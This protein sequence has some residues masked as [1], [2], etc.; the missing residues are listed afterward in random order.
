MTTEIDDD[1]DRDANF[2][3]KKRKEKKIVDDGEVDVFCQHG[4][5]ASCGL[6][7]S[8]QGYSNVGCINSDPNGK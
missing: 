3:Q 5:G 8:R 1:D 7:K 6:I 4:G 2:K